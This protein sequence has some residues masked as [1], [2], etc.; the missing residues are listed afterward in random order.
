MQ[1][2]LAELCTARCGRSLL[3]RLFGARAETSASNAAHGSRRTTNQLPGK[4]SGSYHGAGRSMARM[5]NHTR[6]PAVWLVRGSPSQRSLHNA[7]IFRLLLK[8]AVNGTHQ[9][10]FSN[11]CGAQRSQ[12]PPQHARTCSVPHRWHHAQLFANRSSQLHTPH[13]VTLHV[14]SHATMSGCASV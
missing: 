1:P 13:S 3:S 5:S 6:V 7:P 12:L 14:Q 10:D 4:A 9:C 2:Q 11:F 8:V